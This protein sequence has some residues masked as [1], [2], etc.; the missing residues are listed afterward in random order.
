[1]AGKRIQSLFETDSKEAMADALIL[2]EPDE[3]SLEAMEQKLNV[4]FTKQEVYQLCCI[5]HPMLRSH[6]AIHKITRSGEKKVCKEILGILSSNTN[7]LD[8]MRGLAFFLCDK[9]NLSHYTDTL[10]PEMQELWRRLLT[11]FYVSETEAMAILKREENM[12]SHSSSWYSSRGEGWKSKQFYFFSYTRSNSATRL[13]RYGYRE[14]DYF[15]YLY[16]EFYRVFYPLFFPEHEQPPVIVSQLPNEQYSVFD[17]EADSLAK[18]TLLSGMLETKEI[19]FTKRGLSLSDLKRAGKRL[20]MEELFPADAPDPQAGMRQRFY[21]AMNTIN[22]KILQK[23]GA[24]DKS[25]QEQMRRFVAHVTDVEPLLVPCLLPHIKGLRKKFVETGRIKKICKMLFNW[26]MESDDKD[27]WLSIADI[28]PAEMSSD[29][30]E[31]ARRTLLVFDH[32]EQNDDV[33]IVNEFSK[34]KIAVDS[35]LNEFGL[36]TLKSVAVML[37]SLGLVQV[38]LSP[39]HRSESPFARVEYARLTPLGRYAFGLTD[40]YEPPQIEQRAYFEL[41]PE[42]LIIRSLIDP[43]PYGQLLLDSSVS[44]SKNRFETSPSSFL[45]NCHN[46]EDVERKIALFKQFISSEL[47]P[48]WKQFFDS[49]LLHCHPLTTETATYRHYRLSPDN[50]DLIRLITTDE[51]IRQLVIRAEGYLILVRQEDLN[52]FETILKKYGYLL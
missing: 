12:I 33:V 16:P 36:T 27:G 30:V 45:A 34:H 50:T 42:R 1:M 47:P 21:V 37:S 4:H 10:S 40:E 6:S 24:K 28:V 9:S 8:M 23:R 18:Y 26:L 41:D 2:N 22:E 31:S 52:K 29:N 46:R 43:N 35:F 49:L 19:G 25:Y 51:R 20:G 5:L 13:T 38:A 7:K 11:N 17:F 32:Q 15:I 44:I 48:L 39:L 3:C 14:R